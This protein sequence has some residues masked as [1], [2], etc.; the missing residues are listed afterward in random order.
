M[1]GLAA[2]LSDKREGKSAEPLAREALEMLRKALPAGHWRIA[3]AESV[4]G[5]TLAMQRRFEE[6]EPLLVASSQTLKDLR[7]EREPRTRLAL[8]RLTELYKVWG[9]ARQGVSQ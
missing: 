2:I 1:I 4:L 5:A 9:K 3:D 7:G 6:A 8:A